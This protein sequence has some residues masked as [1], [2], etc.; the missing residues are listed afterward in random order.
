MALGRLNELC[1]T[2]GPG[3]VSPCPVAR[4][5]KSA[6]RVSTAAGGSREVLVVEPVMQNRVAGCAAAPS[7]LR[8]QTLINPIR[9]F[10]GLWRG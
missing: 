10:Q 2:L 4:L 6:A 8:V 7:F 1:V 9:H 3:T 5:G